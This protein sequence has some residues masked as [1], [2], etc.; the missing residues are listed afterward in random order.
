MLYIFM[1]TVRPARGSGLRYCV[2]A[3]GD[4]GGRIHPIAGMQMHSRISMSP[5]P[6]GGMG[7]GVS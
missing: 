2:T 5:L 7:I 4:L 6:R 1:G 3:G